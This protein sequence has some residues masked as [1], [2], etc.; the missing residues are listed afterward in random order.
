MNLANTYSLGPFD[1]RCDL[2]PSGSHPRH[3]ILVQPDPTAK[4]AVFGRKRMLAVCA[5]G[6]RQKVMPYARPRK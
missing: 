2:T 5:C 3:R 6:A 1:A 4:Q